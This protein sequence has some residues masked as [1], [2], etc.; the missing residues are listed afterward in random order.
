M[1]YIFGDSHSFYNFNGLIYPHTFLGEYSVTMYR[2]GRDAVLPNFLEEFN[3]FE[4]TFI[5][6]YGEIDCR[7]QIGK[8]IN[9]GRNLEEICNELCINYFKTINSNIAKYKKIIVVCVTPPMSRPYFE[10]I[11]EPITHEYPFIHDDISRI[12]Y[13][14]TLNSFLEKECNKNNYHFLNFYNKYSNESGLLN[15]SLSD[16][17]VHISDNR[18]VLESLYEVL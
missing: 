12:E 6:N 10:S 8:Q 11:N 4:N 17:L 16:N 5:F 1:I 14:I 2:I 9:L 3:N 13:T 18:Y 15:P 7:C